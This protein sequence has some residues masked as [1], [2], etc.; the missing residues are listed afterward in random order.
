MLEGDVKDT[1]DASI[2]FISPDRDPETL[3][4]YCDL[5]LP[6][7]PTPTLRRLLTATFLKSWSDARPTNPLGRKAPMMAFAATC[8]RHIFESET[9][10]LA[11]ANGWPTSIDWDALEDRV[12]AMKSNLEEIIG[13]PGIQIVYDS[14]E[15][16]PQEAP[17]EEFD[18]GSRMQCIFWRELFAELKRSGSRRVSGATGQFATFNKMQ[19][20]YYGELG[21]VII[22]KTL[23]RLFADHTNP[24][25]VHP[26]T[27]REFISRVLVPEVGMRLIM[28]DMS[29]E[30]NMAVEV[31]RASA[32][33]G[34][35]MFPDEGDTEDEAL[36]EVDAKEE[37]E[38]FND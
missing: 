35:S 19:P 16:P 7:T 13:D 3:C 21:S 8:Q 22:H 37:S 11:I 17:V 14:Q 29:L 20:G 36:D 25:L 27:V 32:S 28:E 24:D 30:T 33:Y 4:P 31:L 9:L 10:P 12:V 1:D 23:Y 38:E 34:V 18:Q 5:P 2:R 15:K 6:A 26:L